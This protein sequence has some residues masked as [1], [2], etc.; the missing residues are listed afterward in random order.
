MNPT[1]NELMALL[2]S[3]ADGVVSQDELYNFLAPR[4]IGKTEPEKEQYV[5][6]IFVALDTDGNG[7]VDSYE[8]GINLLHLMN[9]SLVQQFQDVDAD[10]DGQ[11]TKAELAQVL[12]ISE[13]EAERMIEDAD[14]DG[15]GKLNIFEFIAIMQS[16]QE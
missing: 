2:D 11:I 15:D 7:S 3:N 8:L 4:L 13:D 14:S 5:S 1:V 16:L 6:E 12:D 10:N 9:P